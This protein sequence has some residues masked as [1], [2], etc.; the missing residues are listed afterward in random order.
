[1]ILHHELAGWWWAEKTNGGQGWIP[2]RVLE[3]IEDSDSR[4][5]AQG[6]S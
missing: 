1:L 4:R 5:V 2:A 3:A 6:G